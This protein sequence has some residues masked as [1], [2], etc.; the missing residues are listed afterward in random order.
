MPPTT[1]SLRGYGTQKILVTHVRHGVWEERNF[2]SV[3]QILG[4]FVAFSA[5]MD[6]K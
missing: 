4:P 1:W 2:C 5:G 6:Q 3:K